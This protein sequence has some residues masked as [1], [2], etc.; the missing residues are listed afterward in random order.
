MVTLWLRG[1]PVVY[2]AFAVIVFIWLSHVYLNVGTAVADGRGTVSDVVL[3]GGTLQA[4]ATVREPVLVMFV[5]PA[6]VDQLHSWLCNTQRMGDVH[7]RTAL[8]ATDAKTVLA[9]R[10]WGFSVQVFLLEG[11]DDEL[12]AGGEEMV[13]GDANR[14]HLVLRRQQLVEALLARGV[15]L[16]LVDID[17]VWL[18][19][20]YDDP[21]VI[22]APDVDVV[23]THSKFGE[24]NTV[25]A[26]FLR[27]NANS[28]TL[29][30]WRASVKHLIAAISASPSG[31]SVVEQPS[32]MAA[33]HDHRS[34][35]GLTATFLPV[36]DYATGQYFFA[37]YYDNVGSKAVR[38]YLVHNNYFLRSGSHFASK[39]HRAKFYGLWFVGNDGKCDVH[40]VAKV[41][42]KGRPIACKEQLVD[43]SL[44]LKPVPTAAPKPPSWHDPC[45]DDD[46]GF[47]ARATLWRDR[48]RAFDA[49]GVA[50]TQA[51][52]RFMHYRQF[53]AFRH[54]SC[55]E[56]VAP[57]N[58]GLLSGTG[59]GHRWRQLVSLLLDRALP[60]S[61]VLAYEPG[62]MR[63][64]VC[65][66]RLPL[67]YLQ[68]LGRCEF[69]AARPPPTRWPQQDLR[70]APWTDAY[71]RPKAQA[72]LLRGGTEPPAV[73]A[74]PFTTSS[75]ER[76]AVA[77]AATLFALQPTLAM[78]RRIALTRISLGLRHPYLAMHVFDIDGRAASNAP[79][80]N[81][82]AYMAA[83]DAFRARFGV[84]TMFV[85][86]NND[87]L[88]RELQAYESTGWHFAFGR[89]RG[90]SKHRATTGHAAR[91]GS[92]VSTLTDLYISAHADYWIGTLS[93]DVSVLALLMQHGLYGR[94]GPYYSFD[95]PAS[96]VYREAAAPLEDQMLSGQPFHCT[97]R[98]YYDRVRLFAGDNEQFKL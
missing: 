42:E 79:P 5:T 81:V 89:G 18:R 23:A 68:P 82:S 10:L 46:F 96:S 66:A 28:R 45:L 86:T 15:S 95:F 83:A 1:K 11:G 61:R 7:A 32:I 80:F 27:L 53:C 13:W 19:N 73:A 78:A 62:N 65:T 56:I 4:L 50:E 2:F 64:H 31:T 40:R 34:L 75:R 12:F 39:T 91:E 41:L 16:L 52:M 26:C 47:E 24:F 22:A 37:G 17:Y 71:G 51:W 30:F 97:T 84:S 33:F 9:V 55:D 49:T 35:H 6:Y 85:V 69:D 60:A 67:C 20:P 29:A 90:S 63:G 94:L 88:M 8:F 93:S 76:R 3:T 38:P 36:H 77:A 43:T 72:G 74:P 98:N 44:V 87:T 92:V 48:G 14:K 54:V 59:T 25:C 57:V 70:K 58:S 21:R